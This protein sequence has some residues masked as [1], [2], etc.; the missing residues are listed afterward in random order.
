MAAFC[1]LHTNK[2]KR[3]IPVICTMSGVHT[4]YCH[5][6]GSWKGESKSNPDV[7]Y[8]HGAIF[9]KNNICLEKWEKD[10]PV[11]TSGEG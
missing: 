4:G 11:I 5:E 8:K 3:T 6:C 10:H 1:Y 7:E 2:D 9:C